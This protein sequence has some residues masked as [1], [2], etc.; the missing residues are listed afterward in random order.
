MRLLEIL[1][2]VKEDY[3]R[4]FT[5]NQNLIQSIDIYNLAKEKKK[6]LVAQKFVFRVFLR[7]V[8]KL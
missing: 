6:E 3:G 7:L 2:A 1:M 5:C 8:L 4:K